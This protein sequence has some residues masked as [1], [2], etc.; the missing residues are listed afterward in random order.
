M[1]QNLYKDGMKCQMSD[2][3]NMADVSIYLELKVHNKH[4][5]AIGGPII[6]VCI[7]H[8]FKVTFDEICNARQFKII[9]DGF[10]KIGKARPVRQ[11]CSLDIRPTRK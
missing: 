2:C 7:D 1:K 5:P 11:F 4:P 9:G 6:H 8:G 10:E 3:E